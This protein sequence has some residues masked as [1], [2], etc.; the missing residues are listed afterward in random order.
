MLHSLD[1]R[2]YVV[3]ELWHISSGTLWSLLLKQVLQREN[4]RENIIFKNA[5]II[6]YMIIS[7]HIS[8]FEFEIIHS[9]VAYVVNIG[10]AHL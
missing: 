10:S 3:M 8:G 7:M 5:H 6:Q 1:S 2:I 4:G 9:M